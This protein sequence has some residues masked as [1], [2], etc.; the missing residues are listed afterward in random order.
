MWAALHLKVEPYKDYA[1]DLLD[2]VLLMALCALSLA[3]LVFQLRPS[4]AADLV[5]DKFDLHT[6][7]EVLTLAAVL[8][9][10]LA[11]LIAVACELVHRAREHAVEGLLSNRTSRLQALIRGA[12]TRKL[13]RE[14][15]SVT[16]ELQSR[17]ASS[18]AGMNRLTF[19]G[20]IVPGTS[21]DAN[22]RRCMHDP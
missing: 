16:H 3:S 9:A 7:G 19:R 5:T 14:S 11:A 6:A 20:Q 12:S 2:C 1:L 17:T 22:A 13:S 10:V 21:I 18:D 8:L 4:A 15:K